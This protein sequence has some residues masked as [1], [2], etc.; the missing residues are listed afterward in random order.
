MKYTQL[1]RK[2]LKNGETIKAGW[3]IDRRDKL[4][5]TKRWQQEDGIQSIANDLDKKSG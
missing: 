5:R 2:S 3:F 1:K 4:T